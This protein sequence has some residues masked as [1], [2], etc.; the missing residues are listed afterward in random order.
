MAPGLGRA[1]GASV[2]SCVDRYARA[3]TFP[4]RLAT[5]FP[6]LQLFINSQVM[7]PAP[8]AA[9]VSMLFS[10]GLG[11][12]VPSGPGAMMASVKKSKDLAAPREP[13]QLQGT[14][15]LS[16]PPVES[17][18]DAI[19]RAIVAQDAV[20]YPHGDAT[21]MS[22]AAKYLHNRRYQIATNVL[23]RG[24]SLQTLGN[25]VRRAR[26]LGTGSRGQRSLHSSTIIEDWK[27]RLFG[28]VTEK[29]IHTACPLAG[30]FA[31]SEP[32]LESEVEAV[33]R[34][35]VAQDAALYPKGDATPM[36]A[37]PKYFSDSFYCIVTPAGSLEFPLGTLAAWVRR[38]RGF[39]ADDRRELSACMIISE[40][41]S[42]LF[43]IM[44]VAP[45]RA[46]RPLMGTFAFSEPPL[47]PEVDAIVRAIVAQDSA[48]YPN[49]AV[50]P[51]STGR[52]YFRDSFYQI[53]TS[54]G[55]LDVSLGTLASWVRRARGL[56]TNSDGQRT[57]PSGTIIEDW[58]VRL[59]GVV[60]EKKVHTACPLA[61]T[62]V[63]SDPPLESEI[64]AIVRAIVAQD[65][66]LYPNG[67]A[68]MMS[69]S[70]KCFENPRYQI[71]T[72]VG[73][74][75]LPLQTLAGWVRRARG[76]K[77]SDKRTLPASTIIAEWKFRLFGIRTDAATLDPAAIEEWFAAQGLSDL[78]AALRSAPD[79]LLD[80]LHALSPEMS[81]REQAQQVRMVAQW[82]LASGWRPSANAAVAGVGGQDPLL[83]ALMM[84]RDM[85][86]RMSAEQLLRVQ[87][88]MA[89]HWARALNRDAPGT[90]Q[91]LRQLAAEISDPR[92]QQLLRAVADEYAAELQWDVESVRTTLFPFQRTGAKFLARRTAAL[93]ADDTGLGKTLEA[94]AAVEAL[95]QAGERGRALIVAPASVKQIWAQRLSMDA[96][97]GYLRVPRR[98]ALISGDREMRAQRALAAGDA[99]YVIVN[100]EYLANASAT[101][102]AAL[103]DNLLVLIVDE[104]QLVQ[105]PSDTIQRAAAVRQ[106][107]APRT[108]LLT[109]TPFFAREENLWTHLNMLEPGQHGTYAEFRAA[110]ARD[111]VGRVTLHR[112]AQNV[113]LRRRK[114]DVLGTYDPAL[115][116]DAQPLALPAVRWVP[117]SEAGA[118]DMSTEQRDAA[119]LL[120]TDFPT[121][122]ETYG[123]ADRAASSVGPLERLHFL[124]Q[125]QHEPERLGINGVA[126][127]LAAL[128]AL[129]LPR[130][131]AG[132][133]VVLYVNR[134]RQAKRLQE[135]YASHGAVLF[136][137]GIG[138]TKK[139]RGRRAFQ[140]GAAKILVGTSA[141]AFGIDLTAGHAIILV[142]EPRTYV[143]RYQVVDRLVRLDPQHRRHA[144]DVIR[145]IGTYPPLADATPDEVRCLALGSYSELVD[146]Y[147]ERMGWIFHVVMD[148]PFAETEL[149]KLLQEQLHRRLFPDATGYQR[150]VIQA[151]EI[152]YPVHVGLC[153]F[154]VAVQERAQAAVLAVAELYVNNT[155]AAERLRD[156]YLAIQQQ[157]NVEF[158]VAELEIIASLSHVRNKTLRRAA[159]ELLPSALTTL[160]A[161][162]KNLDAVVRVRE[163]YQQTMLLAWLAV[164][165]RDN[166]VAA[167]EAAV[168]QLSVMESDVALRLAHRVE[169][170]VQPLLAVRDVF[171][172]FVERHA[173]VV[174]AS[175]LAQIVECLAQLSATCIASPTL[176]AMIMDA[177]YDS[178]DAVIAD[179][180]AFA[181]DVIVEGL[182]LP[183]TTATQAAVQTV[184]DSGA[185]LAQ[186]VTLA[187]SYRAEE[188]VEALARLQ[189]IAQHVLHG[190]FAQWRAAG[191]GGAGAFRADDIALW[192]A[193]NKSYATSHTLDNGTQQVTAEL[194][195]AWEEWRDTLTACTAIESP[196]V[197]ERV[198]KFLQLPDDAA[199]ERVLAHMR[200]ALKILE[201]VAVR[202]EMDAADIA[203]VDGVFGP[204]AHKNCADEN[205]RR[206]MHTALA[207][208]V[209]WLEAIAATQ[210][211]MPSGKRTEFDA[212]YAKLATLE[213]RF[214]A[215]LRKKDPVVS[216]LSALTYALKHRHPAGRSS[217]V[218]VEDRADWP[219]LVNIGELGPALVNCLITTGE[220]KF[221]ETLVDVLGNRAQRLLIVRSPDSGEVVAWAMLKLR[222]D[223]NG[224]PVVHVERPFGPQ[225]AHYV[226]AFLAHARHKRDAM[227][228]DTARPPLTRFARNERERDAGMWLYSAGHFGPVEHVED[229]FD[230]RAADQV[231]FRAWVVE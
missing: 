57:L 92:V 156:E 40:W 115:P 51:M 54:A 135:R 229:L 104:A 9:L 228:S 177:D 122:W 22:T 198:G 152:F 139:E 102:I 47:E 158:P 221:A 96:T 210:R 99:D 141:M 67:D 42:R 18:I 187:Q 146:E 145:L 168:D 130:I 29:K 28:V 117:P 126:T 35:I 60:I 72:S 55:R 1:V 193:W 170:S 120:L 218:R 88:V 93:L 10:G 137:G 70:D 3:A 212:A 121:F 87:R 159:L 144:I 24:F 224:A 76:L 199:R 83:R 23:I 219:M 226:P 41:K 20:W 68:T 189:E 78:V 95:W 164:A 220:A 153:S 209:P 105:N 216:T 52:K 214:A 62:F 89:R 111:E 65:A 166:A 46:V 157:L 56:K 17:E 207:R 213:R 2:R 197:W 160:H 161:A 175:D 34:A 39:K 110:H 195:S 91:A 162:G 148:L 43:G 36:N 82:Q 142:E 215:A 183:D 74:R 192:N 132:Q 155:D 217:T 49:G 118:Y 171:G 124:Y 186:L 151:G 103:Q 33:V 169:Q 27:V 66:A 191:A 140:N 119:L 167:L 131:A 106:I 180:R 31:L 211:A 230:V 50:A 53:T 182:G 16:E 58:K 222:R 128:D 205:A 150:K 147:L 129:V 80:L 202:P 112:R 32:P 172:G 196:F 114:T 107:R 200:S 8:L 85:L 11:M 12:C 174:R 204:G 154:D 143:E 123:D 25:Q 63:L 79:A 4:L 163:S 61:G 190:D 165:G 15:T 97:D 113:M 116:L 227:S 7:N 134:R 203:R 5:R 37:G 194:H 64:D 81:E 188:K 77:C 149:T 125:I 208:L 30:T 44:E 138:E 173:D 90:L 48:L 181:V 127:K 38:A 108:W 178:I 136:W 6:A 206:R 69:V 231:E 19:V 225:A 21:P 13:L 86:E 26:G 184:L 179:T 223:A 71:T 101:E 73:R 98:V 75:E 94:I 45:M 185:P 100:P 176:F 201:R 109:A 84:R 14:F 59:F 133:Q